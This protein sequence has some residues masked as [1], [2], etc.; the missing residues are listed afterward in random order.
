MCASCDVNNRYDDVNHHIQEEPAK[1]TVMTTN[2]H[3][4]KTQHIV[5]KQ[6]EKK[7]T[8]IKR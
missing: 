6:Q 2:K 4:T 3:S 8:R 1:T 7:N 5:D